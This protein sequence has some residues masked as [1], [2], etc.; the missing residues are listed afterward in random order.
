M[1]GDKKNTSGRFFRN[2]SE[3]AEVFEIRSILLHHQV[4]NKS[5]RARTHCTR[6]RLSPVWSIPTQFVRT[7]RLRRSGV[8]FR[9]GLKDVIRRTF[10]SLHSYLSNVSQMCSFFQRLP[11]ACDLLTSTTGSRCA[12][13]QRARRQ[14]SASSVLPGLL[15]SKGQTDWL[16][17]TTLHTLHT[18]KKV[19][20]IPCFPRSYFRHS[21]RTYYLY[22]TRWVLTSWQ[23]SYQWEWCLVRRY[24]WLDKRRPSV[25]DFVM[26]VL[27]YNNS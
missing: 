8:G 5:Y 19:L 14:F 13:A 27:L 1:Q 21:P 18:G 2:L 24:A 26:G 17:H 10:I 20:H 23:C 15:Q 22:L 3:T 11:N 4:F 12:R 9:P 6:D 16:S 7:D 25:H